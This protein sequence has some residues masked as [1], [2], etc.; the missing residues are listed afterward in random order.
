MGK[1]IYR[2]NKKTDLDDIM[3]NNYYKPIF[4]TMMSSEKNK[5]IQ[6]NLNSTLLALAKTCTYSMILIIDFDDFDDNIGFFSTIQN[7][8]LPHFITFLTGKQYDFCEANDNFIPMIVNKIDQ[9]HKMYLNKLMDVFNPNPTVSTGTGT[10]TDIVQT[11]EQ[12]QDIEEQVKD[13]VKPVKK[14]KSSKSTKSSKNTN[15]SS[16]TK[17]SNKKQYVETKNISE[18]NSV[19]NTEHCPS[20][21]SLTCSEHGDT[22]SHISRTE[23]DASSDQDEESDVVSENTEEIRKRKQKLKKLKELKKIQEQLNA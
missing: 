10:G 20:V 21:D 12:V 8:P 22:H 13:I 16:K 23:P 9:F 18:N 6:S 2:V 17:V 5:S 14:S 15:Q 1:N 19:A 11:H 4:I 7:G 3:R